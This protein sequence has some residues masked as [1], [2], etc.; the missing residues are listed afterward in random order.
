MFD[1][2]IDKVLE[3]VNVISNVS[4][5]YAFEFEKYFEKRFGRYLPEDVLYSSIDIDGFSYRDFNS[6]NI[7]SII[8]ETEKIYNFDGNFLILGYFS[9]S[10]GGYCIYNYDTS[11]YHFLNQDGMMEIGFSSLDGFL[12]H[13]VFYDLDEEIEEEE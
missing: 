9:R 11:K 6:Y 10:S 1:E 2:F 7:T 4:A 13:Y 3:E 12:G 8:N 5:D